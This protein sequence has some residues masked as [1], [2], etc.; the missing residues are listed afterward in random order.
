MNPKTP[1]LKLGTQKYQKITHSNVTCHLVTADS[2]S[3][4]GT[5]REN[6]FKV[7]E[8]T[9]RVGKDGETLEQLA[10]RGAGCPFLG[11]FQARLKVAPSNPM[12]LKMSLLIEGG[13]DQTS[14]KRDPKR[15]LP[16]QTMIP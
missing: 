2:T 5:D 7:K 14:F 9:F 1:F 4:V 3:A 16:T 12:E 13:L 15:S 6:G 10:Q 8:G 11:K